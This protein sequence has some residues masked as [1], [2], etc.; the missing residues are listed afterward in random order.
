MRRWWLLGVL[1]GLS[2]CGPGPQAAPGADERGSWPGGWVGDSCDAARADVGACASGLVCRDGSCDWPGC[3][4]AT[5]PD[6]WCRATAG[7]GSACLMG[8]CE[9]LALRAGER[10]DAD[11]ECGAGLG[12]AQRR[13]SPRCADDAGCADGDVCEQ[14]RCVGALD[15]AALEG[16]DEACAARLDVSRAICEAGRCVSLEGTRGAPCGGDD[17]CAASHVCE[18]GRCAPLCSQ[19][20]CGVG[21]SCRSRPSGG[22]GSVCAL[23]LPPTGCALEADP[24]G[25]CQLLGA[26]RCDRDTGLCVERPTPIGCAAQPNPAEYC[27]QELGVAIPDVRCDTATGVCSTTREPLTILAIVDAALVVEACDELMEINGQQV[28][29]PGADITRINVRRSNAPL[30]TLK[31]RYQGAGSSPQ[32][33]DRSDVSAIQQEAQGAIT[34]DEAQCPRA[35]ATLEPSASFYS[36]G[37]GG[38]LAVSMYGFDDKPIEIKAGDEVII[39]EYGA[40]CGASGVAAD[41]YRA[42]LC[43]SVAALLGDRRGCQDLTLSITT[44]SLQLIVPPRI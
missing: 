38:V 12:C 11:E 14:E 4:Q 41:G 10:C 5:D 32:G 13:C 33:N 6:G 7:A 20:G 17:D 2:A 36:L 35:P 9:A 23:P 39:G 40:A 28:R 1:W 44:E 27:A 22:A 21:L 19:Q 24:D 25:S 30:G 43:P 26:L 15:C 37:C 29:S 16:A 42:Y 8:S 34:F 31:P 3:A 18:Q